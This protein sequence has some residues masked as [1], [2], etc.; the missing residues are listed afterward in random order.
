MPWP[1]L[2]GLLAVV[3]AAGLAAA[4]WWRY[5]RGNTRVHRVDRPD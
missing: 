3:A 5:R 1:V 2:T 4:G